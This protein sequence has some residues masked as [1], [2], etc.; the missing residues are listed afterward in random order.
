MRAE[1]S[2]LTGIALSHV[3][4]VAAFRLVEPRSALLNG[5]MKPS[6]E[7]Q[8]GRR[9]LA[10]LLTAVAEHRDRSAFSEL[11]G[12]FAPR[13]KA[14]MRRRGADE[15][16]AEDLVQDV[17]LT[18]WRRASL[19]DR[20]QASVST[21]IFTIARNKHI[22][23]L[24]RERRPEIDPED[25][26][27]VADPKPAVDQLVSQDQISER[28]RAAVR[29]LPEEQADVLRKNFFE[30]KPHKVVA[31]ELALPLGTVKSRIRLALA[32]LRQATQ[33]LE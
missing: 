29:E 13:I 4:N 28:L 18:V 19:Y 11:F 5:A 23:A 12:Y 2:I 8:D 7:E 22:D 31:D 25:P 21:W 1:I 9:R 15:V 17:M 32:K 27:L 30:D 24:R 16:L 10:L 14:F 20:Q 33:G 6:E 3:P 26:A